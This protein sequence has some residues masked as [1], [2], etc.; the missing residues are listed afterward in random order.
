ML[1]VIALVVAAVSVFTVAGMTAWGLGGGDGTPD[2]P[3]LGVLSVLVS[4]GSIYNAVTCWLAVFEGLAAWQWWLMWVAPVAGA[5]GL[6]LGARLEA[7]ED[8]EPVPTSD[9]VIGL[10]LQ[11]VVAVPAV[12]LGLSDAVTL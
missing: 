7:S 9:V 3:L 6:W 5:V 1:V 10:G 11:A 12:L 2:T 4:T 8:A